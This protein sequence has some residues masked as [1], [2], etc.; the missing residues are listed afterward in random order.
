MAIRWHRGGNGLGI[1]FNVMIDLLK[2][3]KPPD[4]KSDEHRKGR[5]IARLLFG[6]TVDFRRI[7]GSAAVTT[8]NVARNDLAKTPFLRG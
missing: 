3:C 8:T 4:V 6:A 1:A 7:E 2:R 5:A